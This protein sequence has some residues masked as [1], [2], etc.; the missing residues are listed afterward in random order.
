MFVSVS[1]PDNFTS[2]P[3]ISAWLRSLSPRSRRAYGYYF[4]KFCDF[5]KLSP[6]NLL[7][8]AQSDKMKAKETL[9]EFYDEYIRKGYTLNT[10]RNALVTIKSFLCYNEIK[11]ARFPRIGNA[12]QYESKRIFTH[13]EVFRMLVGARTPRNRA[14]ISFVLQSGQRIGVIRGIRYGDVRRQIEKSMSPVVV[15]VDPSISK[16]MIRH[17]FAI[18]RECVELIKVMMKDREG[19][20]ESIDDESIL[21]R[22]LGLGTR[23]TNGNFVPGGAVNRSVRGKPICGSQIGWIM[24]KAA[25]DGGVTLNRLVNTNFPLWRHY[26]LHPHAFRRWWKNMMRK[27]GVKDPVFLD[28]ILGHHE[29]YHGAYDTFDHDYIRQEYQKAE[30]NLTFLQSYKDPVRASNLQRIVDE[31]EATTLFSE[32]WRYVTTLPSG[33]LVVQ[34]DPSQTPTIAY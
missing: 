13:S 5:S 28:Y 19:W 15:D 3:R 32:G 11:F 29:P 16:F 9:L 1:K 4:N 21:F 6:L 30:Q 22:S 20:G 17:S 31:R 8:L 10:S 12:P 2:D 23:M 27:G 25:T 33:N 24:R 14:L 18:G 7:A 26:E 34:G